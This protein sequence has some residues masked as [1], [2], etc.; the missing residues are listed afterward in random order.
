[1]NGVGLLLRSLL[2][3]FFSAAVAPDPPNAVWLEHMFRSRASHKLT[4][5]QGS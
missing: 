1:M 4:A 3:V 5:R 2:G